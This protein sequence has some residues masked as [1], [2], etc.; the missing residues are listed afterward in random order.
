MISTCFIAGSLYIIGLSLSSTFIQNILSAFFILILTTLFFLNLRYLKDK[1]SDSSKNFFLLQLTFLIFGIAITSLFLPS[2]QEFFWVQDSI[3]THLPESMKFANLLTGDNNIQNVGQAS[4]ATTHAVTGAAIALLGKNTFST[5]FAQY[6]FKILTIFCIYE[7]SRSL[8]GKKIAFV[9][10]LL[11]GLSPTIFFYNLALYKES[12]VQ[13]FFAL[14]LLSSIKIFIEKKLIY[15]L[16]FFLSIFLLKYERFYIAYLFS[17]MIYML[18]FH[19]FFKYNLKNLLIYSIFTLLIFSLG[20]YI[21]QDL[22]IG[23]AQQVK[24]LRGH[25]SSFGDVVNQ[26]N[27]Q[28]PYLLALIKIIFSPYFSLNKFSIFTGLSSLLTWGSFIN[29]IIILSAILG[30]IKSARKNILHLYL[31]T[32]F[33]LFLLF[34]AYISPWS[35]RIRDSFYPLIACYAAYYLTNNKYFKKISNQNYEN[36]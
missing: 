15:L 34:S 26:F 28:I 17:P 16:L 36:T 14:L 3:I 24:Q 4:G 5:I 11:Y 35:G 33:I 9:S 27:Y 1:D 7:I 21:Y 25:Y 18:I 32:P 30:L 6:L 12:A 31:W 23:L 19:L 13:A 29:Q 22:I 20:V 8:W 2:T 10:I